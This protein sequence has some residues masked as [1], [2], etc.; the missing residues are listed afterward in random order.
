M[1]VKS[2]CAKEDLVAKRPFGRSLEDFGAPT[3]PE[4]KLIE[5]ARRGKLLILGTPRTEVELTQEHA[6]ELEIRAELL[7]FLVLGGDDENPVHEKGPQI[8]GAIIR[9]D[10][11]LSMSQEVRS[12]SLKG[13]RV[14]GKLIIDFARTA[15]IFLDGTD[16]RRISANRAYVHGSLYLRHGF[17]CREGV[18]LSGS[19]VTGSIACRGGTFL[20]VEHSSE[21]GSD[22]SHCLRID[23]AVI[24]GTLI[25]GP[26]NAQEDHRNRVALCGS[27][28]L[29]GTRCIT[30]FDHSSTYEGIT[31]GSDRK[32]ELNGFR[33]EHL[34]GIDP[35][36]VSWRLEW[37]R[38]QFH[39]RSEPYFRPQPFE[40]LAHVLRQMGHESD[41]RAVLIE[42][43][44]MEARIAR[45]RLKGEEQQALTAKKLGAA[46][47]A[48]AG[49]CGLVIKDCLF[50]RLFSYGYAPARALVLS[51]LLIFLGSTIF[52]AAYRL[53]AI[54]PANPVVALRS[55][56]ANCRDEAQR[57]TS[58]KG[59]AAVIGEVLSDHA[60]WSDSSRI[61]LDTCLGAK[62]DGLPDYPKFHSLWYSVDTLVP[63][64]NLHQQDYWLPSR[65]WGFAGVY[66]KFHIAL[67]WLLITFGLAGI[68]GVLNRRA[69]PGGR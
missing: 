13:C 23:D 48:S 22:R 56:W 18:D 27:V 47:V 4:G 65:Q 51:T 1:T 34:S 3:D 32:L 61:L 33:Y 66:L 20:S 10:L 14:D 54:A 16:V 59:T 35:T 58:G 49:R 40:Q 46:A 28:S 57:R 6:P 9:V 30:L 64:L 42:R 52:G 29:K 2:G 17:V 41:A 67:G 60:W 5:C 36:N 8:E 68:L 50:G 21:H 62:R 7:R 11:D 39:G 12:F 26:R 24:D 38:K 63:I 15:S 69:A 43:E 31:E 25:L 37:L 55:E 45:L 19:H 53:G 44:K